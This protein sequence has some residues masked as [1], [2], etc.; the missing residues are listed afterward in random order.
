MQSI[1]ASH[2]GL[3]GAIPFSGRGCG[4]RPWV[5]VTAHLRS[6]PLSKACPSQQHPRLAVMGKFP[7]TPP[8]GSCSSPRPNGGGTAPT[9]GVVQSSQRRARPPPVLRLPRGHLRTPPLTRLPLALCH[10]PGTQREANP[11]S[12]FSSSDARR[13]SPRRR[14]TPR[15]KVK[16]TVGLPS[17]QRARGPAL[18]LGRKGEAQAAMFGKGTSRPLQR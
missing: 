18:P 14:L 15:K 2:A 11:A 3:Q 5:P 16:I 9:A 8:Y 10:L 17:W 6:P 1:G 4:S 13:L 7:P 12:S